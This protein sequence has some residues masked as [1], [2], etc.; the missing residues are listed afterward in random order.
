MAEAGLEGFSVPTADGAA[1]HV[2]ATGTGPSVVFIHGSGSPGLFW[3]PVL[4][5]LESVRALAV[6][7][8]GFGL[9]DPVAPAA[10]SKETAVGWID[11]LLD[12]LE[13]P[14]AILVGHSMGGLWS[15]RFALA[16]PERV[17][18]LAMLGAPS[19]PGT[20]APLP[21][22]LMGTPGVGSLISRQSE[23]SKSVRKFAQMMGEGETL[24]A[25]PAM[26]DLLVAVGN[27]PVAG[28]ALHEEVRAL[29]S[30][31]AL[32]TRSGFRRRARITEADLHGVEVPTLLVGGDHD[33]VGGADVAR[34]VQS[35]IPHAELKVFDG[36]HAPWL[37]QPHQVASVLVD[38][39]QR[40][41]GDRTD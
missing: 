2:M 18:G 32:A 15:L 8:P 21:F 29:I 17:T 30:P 22:R 33:P 40:V 27:D 3:L 7:R 11:R 39:V 6:D 41:D 38:W 34:R 9:S 1:V 5:E 24:G 16:R 35:L 19:L 20:Q 14:S 13:L 36:G 23:T 37:G 25:H 10:T 26:V 28:R 4:Q 31:V 12:A